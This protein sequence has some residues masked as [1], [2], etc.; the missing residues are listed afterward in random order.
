M[1]RVIAV[2]GIVFALVNSGP[3]MA[4]DATDET[5]GQRLTPEQMIEGVVK[6]NSSEAN[7]FT[8]NTSGGHGSGFIVRNDNGK[9][10]IF[11]NRHVVETNDLSA[12][13]L[14]V[15]FNTAQRK[16]EIVKGELLFVSRLH[17]FAVIEVDAALLKRAQIRVLQL[18]DSAQSRL[19]DFVKNERYLRGHPVVAIGNPFDGSNI[20]TYGQ[21]T[22]L[23]FDPAQG[24]FIQTQTPINP[25]NSGGPLLSDVTSEVIGINTMKYREADGV[26]FSIP[27]GVVVE[28]FMTWKKQVEAKSPYTVAQPRSIG[29]SLKGM[30]EE[31]AKSMKVHQLIGELAPGYWDVYNGILLVT[32]FDSST[33]LQRDDIL[34][35]M[36][37][38]VIG[39]FSY[40]LIRMSLLS[41]KEAV[42]RVIRKGEV[43]EVKS[44]VRNFAYDEM[45]RSVN[46][47][48]ISGMF[49]Q[50]VADS[51]TRTTRPDLT[52][53]VV[54]SGILDT[55][56]TNFLGSQSYPPPGSVITAVVFGDKEYKVNS[57]FDLKKAINENRGEQ[58]IRVRAYRANYFATET[59][60]KQVRSPR[61]GQVFLDGTED[62]FVLPMRDVFTPYQFSMNKFKRQFNFKMDAAGTR[63]WQAFV[64]RDLLPSSCLALLEAKKVAQA[65]Q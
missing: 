6:I 26:N 53:S 27:I 40:D 65:A 2:L 14:T 51:T 35:T 42:F 28:E 64:K 37:G 45:R 29:I 50:Q 9:I 11:T 58:T 1:Q 34:L 48:Y 59:G 16:P 44:L 46:F 19:F 49:V 3:A 10:L 22:G 54:V 18:P 7:I 55:P 47:V 30:T 41:P 38:E 32:D 15:E 60:P 23:K 63:D 8:G 36:N 43:V 39:E 33:T 21:V 5:L 57:L 61:T 25:G 31:V 56:D 12:T 4:R 20:T 62:V 52:S 13:K 17:D 24:P